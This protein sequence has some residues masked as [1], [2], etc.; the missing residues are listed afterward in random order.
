MSIQVFNPK[1]LF[2]PD[3]V[4]QFVIVNPQNLQILEGIEVVEYLCFPVAEVHL[5]RI[6]CI[7]VILDG[8]DVPRV[9]LFDLA[10]CS[11]NQRIKCLIHVI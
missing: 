11:S 4:F 10:C 7:F 9:C 6:L 3:E 1:V 5:S 2:D 8:D